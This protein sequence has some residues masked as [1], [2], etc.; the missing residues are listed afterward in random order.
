VSVEADFFSEILPFS[1]D[2]V[3]R[4]FKHEIKQILHLT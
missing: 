1:E 3:P 4:N 2:E